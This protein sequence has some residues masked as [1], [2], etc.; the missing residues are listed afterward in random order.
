LGA[1]TFQY[2][3]EPPDE[4]PRASDSTLARVL[5]ES[6]PPRRGRCWGGPGDGAVLRPVA[7]GGL[8]PVVVVVQGRG[9]ETEFHGGPV[10]LQAVILL[11]VY[12]LDR[13]FVYRWAQASSG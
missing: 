11:G 13:D 7:A 12:K 9:G 3:K 4:L 10:D 8:A 2:V 5:A 6:L 1:D